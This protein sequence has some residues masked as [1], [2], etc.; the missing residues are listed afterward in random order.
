[1]KKPVSLLIV[2]GVL[3]LGWHS[4][5][6][7]LDPTL[8]R[9]ATQEY[10][11]RKYKLSN[12]RYLTII[13]YNLDILQPRLFVYDMESKQIVL[14][15]HVSHAW[16]SGLLYATSFSNMLGSEKSCYGTFLTEQQSYQGNFGRALRIEGLSNEINNQALARA[17]VFHAD[18]GYL[19][20]KG[21]F[22]TRTTVNDRLIS[23]IKGHSLVVV[24]K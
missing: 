11:A 20:S 6:S 16:G 13:N 9:K 5:Y 24:Y 14:T 22:M 2:I 8:L 4:T 3:F 15:T 17:V 19:F 12:R 23:L 21:C 10:V 1:M 7:S 18:P